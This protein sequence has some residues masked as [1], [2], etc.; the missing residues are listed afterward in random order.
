VTYLLA[1]GTPDDFVAALLEAKARNIGVLE[2]EAVEYA[3]LLHEVDHA[4]LRGERPT[5]APRD[6]AQVA[7]ARSVGRLEE[8]LDLLARAR[9]GLA[10]ATEAQ[11]EFRIASKSRPGEYPTLTVTGG[12]ARCDCEGFTYRGNY[13]HAKEVT[14]KLATGEG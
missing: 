11:Q 13:S 2:A 3:S 5:G 4:A 7:P 1:E 10:A 8:T 14:R 6:A 9:R 12:I